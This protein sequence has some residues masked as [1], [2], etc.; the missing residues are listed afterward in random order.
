MAAWWVAGVDAEPRTSS[1]WV[2][3]VKYLG[4]FRIFTKSSAV[5]SR[6]R[7]ISFRKATADLAVPRDEV[8]KASRFSSISF[9]SWKEEVVKH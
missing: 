7:G 9:S 6:T 1:S 5:A 3:R 2:F 8:S 4:L